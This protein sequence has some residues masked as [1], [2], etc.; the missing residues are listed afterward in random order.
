MSHRYIDAK[1]PQNQFLNT[2][3]DE[4]FGTL[5][6][7]AIRYCQGRET[8]M[9]D[10]VRKI[11]KSHIDRISDKDLTVLLDDCEYQKDLDLYGD[12]NID[13]PGWLEWK[14]FLIG[15]ENKR[16]VKTD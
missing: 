5:A 10:M 4:E 13:K 7:C 14:D 3:G 9:P 12:P 2:L 6:I 15:E 8:Y 1:R 11:V 16:R